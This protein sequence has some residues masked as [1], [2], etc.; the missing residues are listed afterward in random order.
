[1][2][3]SVQP[4]QEIKN[5]IVLTQRDDLNKMMENLSSQDRALVI[6]GIEEYNQRSAG[7]LKML[8]ISGEE[9]KPLFTLR[10][11]TGSGG[12]GIR[13]LMHE[14]PNPTE[15]NT[16]AFEIIAIDYRKNIYRKRG[17]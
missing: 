12:G 17:L 1:M 16:R 4:R 7:Q 11:N 3:F 13:V 9:R 10:I 14:L 2:P 15:G 8:R 6:T 5:Q